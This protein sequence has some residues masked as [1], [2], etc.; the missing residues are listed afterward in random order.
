LRRGIRGKKGRGGRPKLGVGV[1]KLWATI[2]GSAWEGGGH[3]KKGESR[4][5][6]GKRGGESHKKKRK[7]WTRMKQ[8]SEKGNTASKIALSD[9]T[10]GR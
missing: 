7:G 8:L 6:T 1:T 5:N 2:E 10:K 9:Q 4:R 3:S